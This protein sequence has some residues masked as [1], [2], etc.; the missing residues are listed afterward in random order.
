MPSGCARIPT[1]SIFTTTFRSRKK[2]PKAVPHMRTSSATNIGT[3]KDSESVMGVKIFGVS[4]SA[5]GYCYAR[6]LPCRET[7]DANKQKRF[8]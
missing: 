1:S 7:H 3:N 4:G 6:R 5:L 2:S 8:C